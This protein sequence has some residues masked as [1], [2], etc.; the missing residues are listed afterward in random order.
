MGGVHATDEAAVIALAIG[1][2]RQTTNRLALCTEH[3][4]RWQS[5]NCVRQG[6]LFDGGRECPKRSINPDTH[7][8]VMTD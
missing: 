5:A 1:T 6:G 2:G 8:N 7:N 3:P 4:W